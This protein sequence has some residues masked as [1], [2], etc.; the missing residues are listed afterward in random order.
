MQNPLAAAYLLQTNPG[1]GFPSPSGDQ[2]SSHAFAS[3]AHLQDISPDAGLVQQLTNMGFSKARVFRACIA[4][5]NS[6]KRHTVHLTLAY[7]LSQ[8]R[9]TYAFGSLGAAYQ[10]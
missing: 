10:Y 5:Q 9:A 1:Q 2:I 7:H 8:R 4:T 3:Q 6:G